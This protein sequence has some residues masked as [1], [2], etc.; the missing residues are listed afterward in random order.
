VHRAVRMAGITWLALGV[1]VALV[2]LFFRYFIPAVWPPSAPTAVRYLLLV[3]YWIANV[4]AGIYAGFGRPAAAW[5]RSVA[6]GTAMVALG[7]ILLRVEVPLLKKQSV[8]TLWVAF[9]WTNGAAALVFILVGFFLLFAG[10]LAWQFRSYRM[11]GDRRAAQ[12]HS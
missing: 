1:L 8:D 12:G 2:L 6:L 4:C 7:G 3:I 9:A 10:L 11:R 5:L